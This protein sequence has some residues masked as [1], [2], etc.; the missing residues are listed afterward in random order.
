MNKVTSK[1]GSG[2]QR[3]PV[4]WLSVLIVPE[5]RTPYR[6]MVKVIWLKFAATGILIFILAA[7]AASLSY[8]SLLRKSI[9]RDTLLAENAKLLVEN[10]RVVQLSKDVEKS[11]QSLAR[12]V[13][14]LGG[15]L[16][17]SESVMQDSL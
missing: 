11:R 10:Q 3:K 2:N 5:G 1:T 9:E 16:D 12:I 17:L 13:K 7:V 4:Q 6:Y 14:S 15:K 8:S